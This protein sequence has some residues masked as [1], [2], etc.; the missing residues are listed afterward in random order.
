MSAPLGRA[1]RDEAR[2]RLEAELAVRLT[3]SRDAILRQ[4]PDLY[5]KIVGEAL[6]AEQGDL[7]KAAQMRAAQRALDRVART[8]VVDFRDQSGRRWTMQ[9]YVE[10]AV[11]TGALRA[12]VDA[13]KATYRQRGIRFVYIT[14]VAGQCELCRPWESR[15]VALDPDDAPTVVA[16]VTVVATLDDAIAAGLMHPNCRHRARQWIP[17]RTVIPAPTPDAVAYEA[18][19]RLRYLERQVRYWKRRS[20]AAITP[21]AGEYTAAKVAEWQ[22]AI[23]Q[24]VAA[25]G[26]R[27]LYGREQTSRALPSPP[28][29]RA[30]ARV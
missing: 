22:A 21:N 25:T 7:G 5:R 29:R 3:H 28:P 19:Q 27:R 12:M 2:R 17:G 20:G 6:A 11:R 4:V 14:N 16:G 8:G 18:Q 9:A 10:M 1:V 26:T 23:R 30:P 24:H 13:Q 15:V